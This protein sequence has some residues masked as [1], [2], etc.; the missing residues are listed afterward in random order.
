M[1]KEQIQEATLVSG[2]ILE[3]SQEIQDVFSPGVDLPAWLNI[4]DT[5]FP[6]FLQVHV[7][8]EQGK[9]VRLLQRLPAILQRG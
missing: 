9:L 2:E 6:E 7:Y 5:N 3:T 4:S 8:D 1:P